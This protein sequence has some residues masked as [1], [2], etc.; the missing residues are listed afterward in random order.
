MKLYEIF[1]DEKP[2]EIIREIRI[3][4]VK[5]YRKE[6]RDEKFISE[7]TGFSISYLKKIY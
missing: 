5:K 6:K 7:N 4:L 1:E 2:G 3:S